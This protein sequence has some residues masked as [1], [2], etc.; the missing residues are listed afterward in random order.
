MIPLGIIPG[1]LPGFFKVSSKIT[2]G[3]PSMAPPDFIRRLILGFLQI[4]H[5]I[6]MFPGVPLGTSPG[7]PS[8]ICLKILSGITYFRDSS[9]ILSE[10]WPETSKA[11]LWDFFGN[12]FSDFKLS[13]G[14]SYGIPSLISSEISFMSPSKIPL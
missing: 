8:G 2:R 11:S 14:I 12:S 9:M 6:L 13:P 3:D 7:I 4:L 10:I 5:S 1:L